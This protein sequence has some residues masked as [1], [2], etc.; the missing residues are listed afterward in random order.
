MLSKLL[1]YELKYMIQNMSIFYI[2]AIIFAV[3]T[4]VLFSLKETIIINII[5]QISVGC[6]FA[7]LVNILI[8]VIMR[9]WVRFNTS[10]YKDESYLTHTLPVTK[11]QI[12][13][14]KFI[15]TLVF[16]TISFIVVIISLFIAYYTEERWLM[17]KELINGLSTTF[18]M[19]TTFFVVGLLIVIFLEVFNGIQCGF[20]GMILGNKKNNN[21]LLFSVIS[22]FVAYLLSQSLVL[23]LVFIV[24]LFDNSIMDLFTSNV[25]LTNDSIKILIIVAIIIYI[26]AI[27]AMNI[28]AKVVFNK[29]VNV[30]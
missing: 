7:V 20:L 15:Q 28:I 5:G 23:A 8:N 24:G 12:Y 30:E 1:K 14:S 9:S 18:N 27:I 16:F 2:L 4:R 10:I 6:L 19:N 13:D 25:L 26:I 29:G 22:G 21:K 3:I 17:L 11:N